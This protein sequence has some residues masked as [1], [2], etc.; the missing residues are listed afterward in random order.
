MYVKKDERG[1]V[2]GGLGTIKE[3]HASFL[4][5]YFGISLEFDHKV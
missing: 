2:E 4:P 3:T 1:Q 5:C